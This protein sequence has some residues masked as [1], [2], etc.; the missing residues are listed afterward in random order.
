MAI[1]EL[2]RYLISINA[3]CKRILDKVFSLFDTQFN[4]KVNAYI[5][6][7]LKKKIL[8]AGMRFSEHH[9]VVE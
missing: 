7:L 8:S 9:V 6:Q 4:V 5:Y 1:L 3:R 2:G